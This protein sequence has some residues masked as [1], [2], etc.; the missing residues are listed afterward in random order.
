MYPSADVDYTNLTNTGDWTYRWEMGD[1]FTT[2]LENPATHTYP[3]WGDYEIW[4]YAQSDHCSDSV[5]H[6]IRILPAAP[7]ADFDTVYPAC[8]PHTVQFR[9]NSIYGDTYL[10]EFGDG[11]SST[12]FEPEHTYEEFGLYNV[13]LT[14]T[15]DG[16]REYAYRLVEVY[17]MPVVDFRVAPELVMLPDDELR[18][19]NLS[20]YGS[21]YLWDFGDGNTSTEENP[22]H[23]YTRVG[24]YDISLDV[25]TE[26][27]CTDRVVKPAAVIVDAP[28]VI[29]FPN[30]F[31]PDLDGPN[32]G[33]Y[34]Q[35]EEE[36]NNKFHPYWEGVAEYHLEI[37]TRW[38]EKLFYSNDV[39]MGWDGY[40]KGTLCAQGVYVYKSW[41]YFLNGEPFLEKGDVTLLY[42]RKLGN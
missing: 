14:V 1:G 8:E 36:K 19:F 6:Y 22:R 4:L 38:G 21:T 2:T 7:I 15:G 42:H 13:K 5:S 34:D 32:G 29:M 23:L 25:W 35:R 39:N 31:K 24:T 41:G 9:N 17:R 33:Y 16:G 37:Y 28:G 3:T 20:K 10:W 27:G 30:A 11:N 12:E 18:C 26:N 40:N